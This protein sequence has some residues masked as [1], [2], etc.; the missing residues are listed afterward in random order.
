M[1]SFFQRLLSK[2]ILVLTFKKTNRKKKPKK[3]IQR[4]YRASCKLNKAFL[5]SESPSKP[6][7][8]VPD[9]RH[10]ARVES[11]SCRAQTWVTCSSP[12][13]ASER[14]AAGSGTREL[15][16][17]VWNHTNRLWPPTKQAELRCCKRPHVGGLTWTAG[18]KRSFAFDV[19]KYQGTEKIP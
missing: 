17:F 9:F 13:R 2:V 7:S 10:L 14:S 4:N 3:P 15:K 18:L 8:G 12:G 1:T 16:A 6:V 5:F 11:L 19:Q